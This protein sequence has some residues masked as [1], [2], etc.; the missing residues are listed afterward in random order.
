[1]ISA[2]QYPFNRSRSLVG[3]ADA[4][5]RSRRKPERSS[6]NNTRCSSALYAGLFDLLQL[7]RTPWP[8]P[9]CFW[10][11]LLQQLP[12]GLGYFAIQELKGSL[13]SADMIAVPSYAGPVEMRQTKRLNQRLHSLHRFFV[14]IFD[15][16]ISSPRALAHSGR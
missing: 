16:P 11:E 4:S 10:P 2:D 13:R 8:Y 15:Q 9:R 5:L 7:R 14:V 1:M 6:P 12:L 3:R